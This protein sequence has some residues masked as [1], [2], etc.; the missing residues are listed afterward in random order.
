MY[1]KLVDGVLQNPPVE[2]SRNIK[3]MKDAGYKPVI[4]SKPGYEVETQDAVFVDYI[5]TG[6][7]IRAMYEIV[8]IEPTEEEQII[9]QTN[10]A[11]E[12]LNIN[13][14]GLLP[15]LSDEQA[16]Q[17]PLMFPKWQVGKAYVVGDRVLY[18]GV[19]Y[20]V[21]QAH[22]SQDGWQP[23]VAPSLFAKNLIVKD[24]QGEQVDIPEWEQPDSTNPY[25]TGDKV[26]FEGKVY[27]S[28][29]DNNVWSP[30]D[31]PQGW[32]EVNEVK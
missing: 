14:N 29:I 26:R 17:V 8:E 28:L 11:M 24:E 7:Y 15:N 25:M 13:F 18:L 27:Q 16:L 23:D 9:E 10:K 20:K 31:H 21:L 4:D 19:L 22:T 5:D 32:E 2:I 1:G 6:M 3:Q 30:S 12:L